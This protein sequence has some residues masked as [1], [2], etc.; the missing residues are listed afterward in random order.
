MKCFDSPCTKQ[1]VEINTMTPA[2]TFDKEIETVCIEIT[3][4]KDDL[5][6]EIQGTDK[7]KLLHTRSAPA[8]T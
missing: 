7:T 5:S 6:A 3:K 4:I 2:V 8:T 1:K